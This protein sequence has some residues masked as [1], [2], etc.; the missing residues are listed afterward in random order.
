MPAKVTE[1]VYLPHVEKELSEL[2]RKKVIV[3]PS[4]QN[5]SE[6]AM[7]A[8]ANEFG[9]EITPKSATFLAIPVR[10]EAKERSPRDF[11]LKP[12]FPKD[13]TPYLAKIEGGAVIPYYI[14]KKKVTIPERSYMRSTFDRRETQDKLMRVLKDS[15]KRLIAGAMRADDVTNALGASLAASVK[16]QIAS[17]IGPPNASITI[18]LKRGKSTTLV[19]EG[20]LVKSISWEVVDA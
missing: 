5:G 15:I 16:S 11:D 14:L 4:A 19:D 10:P 2:L 9:A 3:G 12:V 18:A 13:G 7:Y 20:H 8:A 17:N 1:K 6:L